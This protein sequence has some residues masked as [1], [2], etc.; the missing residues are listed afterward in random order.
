MPYFFEIELLNNTIY[1]WLIATAAT[2]ITFV[3]LI[4]IKRL[5]A[6]HLV[7]KELEKRS[8]IDIFLGGALIRTRNYFLLIFAFYIGSLFLALSAT[9]RGFIDTVTVIVFML[10]V[11]IWGTGIINFW[12]NRRIREEMLK[13]NTTATTLTGL[14]LVVRIVFWS[15]ISL[16]ILDSVPGIEISTLVASLGITG[17]AVALAVQNI[18][19]DLFASLSITLDKPFVIG[20]F[21][22]VDD[23]SGSVEYIGLKSTRVRSLSG[24]QLVFS[25]SDLLSSRISNFKR[26]ERRRIAFVI[27]VTYQTPPEKLEIMP[28]IIR[29]IICGH[30]QTTFDRAH[31]KEFS[32]SGLIF[33]VVYFVESPDYMIYMDIQQAINLAI[34]RRLAEEEISFAYPTQ[35][36]FVHNSHPAQ[37]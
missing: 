27:G 21:I 9:V 11:G 17:I 14:G 31:F 15:I 36:V 34:Y 2:L 33:E 32:D 22:R 16:V 12:I 29:G 7:R 5:L 25:N 8:S 13:N 37:V 24:E 23:K 10:Q 4:L 20:D 28:E 35:T 19:G 26:M 30:P 3:L 18:L 6:R 1:T